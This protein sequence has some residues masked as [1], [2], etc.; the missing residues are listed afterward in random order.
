MLGKVDDIF[1]LPSGS[2]I[3]LIFLE[4]K[5]K[6]DGTKSV[7]ERT[8][9]IA[10]VVP[11]ATTQSEPESPTQSDEPLIL[12]LSISKPKTNPTSGST[13]PPDKSPNT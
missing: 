10:E 5:V 12:D 3:T 2:K 6:E 8:V 1:K 7:E 4:P 9:T 13:T 11:L